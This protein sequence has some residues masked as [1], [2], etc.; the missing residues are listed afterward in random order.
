MYKC[1][2][3]WQRSH[4]GEPKSWSNMPRIPLPEVC[5]LLCSCTDDW[6]KVSEL[7]RQHMLISVMCVSMDLAH[8]R[9][10]WHSRRFRGRARMRGRRL[11]GQED[12]GP[13]QVV[14]AWQMR[15]DHRLLTDGQM[16]GFWKI[17]FP[18]R[19]GKL[20]GEAGI[21]CGQSVG[22]CDED[23]SF[24]FRSFCQGCCV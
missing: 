14:L 18:T 8:A 2:H 7:F 3:K 16:T 24:L 9:Y 5:L 11:S 1:P 10:F 4:V 20:R 19:D 17:T 22:D 12:D 23:V 15:P 21:A 13:I 6:H